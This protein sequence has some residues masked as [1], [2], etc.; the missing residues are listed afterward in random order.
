MSP[1][2]IKVMEKKKQVHSKQPEIFMKCPL[3]LGAKHW[4]WKSQAGGQVTFSM[5]TT[6]QDNFRFY[7][8]VFLRKR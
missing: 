6:E 2:I 3:Q 1:Q 4:R 8:Q 5:K 7:W